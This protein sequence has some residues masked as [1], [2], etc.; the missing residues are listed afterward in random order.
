MIEEV[1]EL[2]AE[3]HLLRLS[4]LEVL[5]QHKIKIYQVR[6]A[7]IADARVAEA[8]GGLLSGRQR[9]HRKRRLVVPAIQSLV[10]GIGATEVRPLR[11]GVEG[12]V[13]RIRNLVGPVAEA[14]GVAEVGRQNCR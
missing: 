13:V 8:V 6:S 10:S 4:N 1:E 9:R 11:R 5:L 3:L 7:K 12:E 2:G 14:A